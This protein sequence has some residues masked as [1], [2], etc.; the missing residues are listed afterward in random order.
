EPYCSAF[1]HYEVD[2]I[3]SVRFAGLYNESDVASSASHEG[4][5]DVPGANV[6][7]GRTYTM[8]V[9]AKTYFAIDTSMTS[10]VG[11]HF[12]WNQDGVFTDDEAYFIGHL[13]RSTGLDGQFARAEIQ[14][15][16]GTPAGPTRMRV[17][18]N[19]NFFTSPCTQAG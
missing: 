7:A 17:I 2:P 18:N 5:L 11:A 9:T 1:F 13:H 12:D 4:F 10:R 15:P 6:S 14:V 16:P 19:H 3:T 8:T